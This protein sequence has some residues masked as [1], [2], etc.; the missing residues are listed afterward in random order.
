VKF[1]ACLDNQSLPVEI[2]ESGSHVVF[3]I[4]G[5]SYEGDVIAVTPGRYSILFRGKVFDVYVETLREGECQVALRD[6]RISLALADPRKL[7]SLRSRHVDSGGEISISS[8]MPGKVVRLL[9]A[10]GQA[11]DQGQ[12]IIVIEA[13]KMQNEVKAPRSGTIKSLNAHEGK[14]VTAGEELMVIA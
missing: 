10:E 11:V 13:M 14:T 6:Q 7:K 12:G 2:Q 4:D 1:E 5:E 8:P 3:R 9:V